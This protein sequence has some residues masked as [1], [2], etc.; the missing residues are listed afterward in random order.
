MHL[1]VRDTDLSVGASP[2]VMGILNVTPDSF[3]DGGRYRSTEM[4]LLRAQEMIAEGAKIVDVGGESTRPGSKPIGADEEIRRIDQVVKGL[5]DLGVLVSVDTRKALVARKM[6]EAGAHMINDVS[7]LVFDPDMINVVRDFDV[8]I[9]I[10]HMR[11]TPENMQELTSY[12][13][14]VSEIRADLKRRIDW[15]IERGIKQER[16][17]ID[18]GIGFAK[19]AE[20][21][22]E[23]IARLS[24]LKSLGFPVLVGPSRKSFI[25]KILGFELEKRLEP[26]I[27]CCLVCAMKGADILRVHDPGPV[28][29]A[30]SMFE[31]I[32]KK[33]TISKRD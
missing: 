33:E 25:G 13:D 12:G 16:I 31:V 29:R 4:A 1:K 18:P 7:G 22:I 2:I 26:T 9:V 17:I 32:S 5:V 14:V 19:T 3:W 23:I 8:P 11:G 30:L 15:A 6:L 21:C 27:A 20:Q 24:E 10:M 28:F